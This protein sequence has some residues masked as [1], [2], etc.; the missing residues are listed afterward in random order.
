M[1]ALIEE[2]LNIIAPAPLP[3]THI[4]T[5][6]CPPAH[7]QDRDLSVLAAPLLRLAG[8]RPPHQRPFLLAAAGA[9][10]LVA[11]HAADGVQVAAGVLGGSWRCTRRHGSHRGGR[12]A[13]RGR[14]ERGTEDGESRR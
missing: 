10:V 13:G 4:H 14:G 6:T 12:G 9:D 1:C 3:Q 7:S 11:G 2:R 8:R 5:H